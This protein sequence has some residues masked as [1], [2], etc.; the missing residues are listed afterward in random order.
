MRSNLLFAAHERRANVERINKKNCH[1]VDM[2]GMAVREG[3]TL[4]DE[5]D[6]MRYCHWGMG[7]HCHRC[8]RAGW[9]TAAVNHQPVRLAARH[10]ALDVGKAKN[11]AYAPLRETMGRKTSIRCGRLTCVAV[12]VVGLVWRY[13]GKEMEVT[14]RPFYEEVPVSEVGGFLLS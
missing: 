2:P 7:Q 14:K 13:G 6:F 3:H 10:N 11:Y 1:V 5:K 8:R 4:Q 12:A 9:L